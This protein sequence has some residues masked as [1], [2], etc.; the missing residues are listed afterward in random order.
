MQSEYHLLHA[1]FKHF[2]F[3]AKSNSFHL[4]AFFSQEE[5]KSH[6]K[7]QDVSE[8]TEIKTRQY[9]KIFKTITLRHINI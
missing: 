1:E 7:Q 8:V 2:P 9:V 3:L 5:N 6:L 4:T